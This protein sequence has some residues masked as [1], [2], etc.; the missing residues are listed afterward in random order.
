M[1]TQPRL[2]AQSCLFLDFDGTLV[3][4]AETPESIKVP[5]FLGKLLGTLNERLDGALA[6]V[7]GR[8]IETF[9]RYLNPLKIAMAGIHGLERRNAQ[10]LIK[11]FKHPEYDFLLDTCKQLV[12]A[13]PDLILEQ[14]K[15][16]L[17][18]HFR[19]APDLE[20][21]CRHAFEIAIKNKPEFTLVLGKYVVEVMPSGFSK[22]AAILDYM[23]EKPFMG[24]TPIFI[25][26][27]LTD[28]SGFEAVLS[29]GG[30]AIKVGS[31]P[32]NANYRF[33]NVNEVHEWLLVNRDF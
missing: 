1:H 20:K 4:L 17:A 7:S 8:Q 32:T 13:N 30:T 6:I 23:K 5:P 22:G 15:M 3:D 28:E 11:Q 2:N 16:S 21:T 31:G 19:K 27:D 26:D 29:H 25:G 33:S 9:D 24:R 14:K 12:K 10:G 18:L